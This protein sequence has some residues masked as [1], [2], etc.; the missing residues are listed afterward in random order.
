MTSGIAEIPST[1]P[2]PR[3]KAAVIGS[4]AGAIEALSTILSPLPGMARFPIFIVVHLPPR[5]RSILPEIFAPK[6]RW[7]VAEVEDKTPIE[8]GTIYFAPPDYHLLV[9]N[10]NRL[11]L[12]DDEAVHYCRPSID[13]L[14][15]SAAEVY[16]EGL[17]GIILTG[18]NHDGAMGLSR[19]VASGGGAIVQQ[20]QSAFAAAMPQ[21]AIDACPEAQV[22]SLN[23]I[24]E[25]LQ[26]AVN[27]A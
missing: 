3:I 7:P 21:S 6:C 19:V 13:V 1:L 5:D 23:A 12:S 20:P 22:L 14:F 15:E 26:K 4:S 11:G 18:A 8:P 27:E 9:E 25:Y 17:V 16:R 2:G 24:A 10:E